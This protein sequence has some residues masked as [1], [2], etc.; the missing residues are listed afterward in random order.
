[1]KTVK[2][3][4][5]ILIPGVG[6]IEKGTE[7]KVV[8]QNSKFVYVMHGDKELRLSKEKDVSQNRFR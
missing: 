3:T 2:T 8:R 6:M 4:R 5:K 1:M 7:F